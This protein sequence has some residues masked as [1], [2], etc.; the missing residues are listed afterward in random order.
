MPASSAQKIA[1]AQR[2]ARMLE[3][4]QQGQTWEDIA[5]ELGYA[6]PGAASKDCVRAL[7]QTVREP[8]EGLLELELQRLDRYTR[9]CEAL[10]LDLRSIDRLIALSARRTRLLGLDA[11]DQQVRDLEHQRSMLGDL[12]TQLRDLADT[13]A[14]D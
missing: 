13:Q 2:R 6:S 8:A 5:A 3:L 4:R 11:I 1:T 7:R 10:G 12:A 14:D 9:A